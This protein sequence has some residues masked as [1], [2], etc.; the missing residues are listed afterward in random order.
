MKRVLFIAICFL[1][2]NE[3]V[4]AQTTRRFSL[5]ADPQLSWFT[6][7][8]RKFDPNGSIGGFNIGFTYDKYFA[9]RYAI[10]LGLSINNVGGNLKYQETGYK[11]E[12]RDNTYTV[13]RGSNVKLKAQFLNVPVG[14]KFKTNEIGYVSFNAQVGVSGSIRLKASVWEDSNNIEKETITQ[15]FNQVYGSYFIGGGVEYSLGGPS[16]LQAG[17]IYSNGI[18]EAYSAGFGKISIGSLSLRI[19]IVF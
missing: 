5:F 12:T 1:F 13:P 2:L 15:Q 3:L 7:D 11:L 19:G 18:T 14:L 4:D 17:I 6:S 8:T 16:S 10:F 9:E